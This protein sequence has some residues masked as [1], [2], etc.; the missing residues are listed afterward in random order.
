MVIFPKDGLNKK[1]SKNGVLSILIKPSSLFQNVEFFCFSFD[2]NFLEVARPEG[3]QASIALENF[4]C[5]SYQPSLFE[6]VDGG[7]DRRCQGAVVSVLVLNNGS[8]DFWTC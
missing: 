5:W 3:I 4:Q 2:P 8:N 1:T 6:A 7:V